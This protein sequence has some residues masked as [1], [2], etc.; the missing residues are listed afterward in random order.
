VRLVLEQQQR[1]RIAA[2]EPVERPQLVTADVAG[3]LE[4]DPLV[5][6]GV[7]RGQPARRL[8]PA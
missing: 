3:I 7:D 8:R 1:V 2:G 6:Q 5:Q 4:E